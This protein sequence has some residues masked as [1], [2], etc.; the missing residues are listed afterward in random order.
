MVIRTRGIRRTGTTR[1]DTM[2]QCALPRIVLH[3]HL[4]LDF[5]ELLRACAR[6]TIRGV[7]SGR[8]AVGREARGRARRERLLLGW[9]W[10]LL[11]LLL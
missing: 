9:K 5:L 4:C 8:E 11:L 7:R 6:R 10:K 1:P 2:M 3:Q